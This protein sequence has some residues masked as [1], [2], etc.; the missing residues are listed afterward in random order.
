MFETE[1]KLTLIQ[2]NQTQWVDRFINI[3]P[4]EI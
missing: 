3:Y 2:M 4:D 1:M